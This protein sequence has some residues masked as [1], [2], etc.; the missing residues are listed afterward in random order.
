MKKINESQM[1]GAGADGKAFRSITLSQRR[2]EELV[3][4]KSVFQRQT[5]KTV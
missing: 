4:K 5:I 3:A 2:R 1:S